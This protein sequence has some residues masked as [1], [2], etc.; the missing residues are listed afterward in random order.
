MSCENCGKHVASGNNHACVIEGKVYPISDYPTQGASCSTYEFKETVTGKIKKKSKDPLLSFIDKRKNK[1]AEES[2]TDYKKN[3]LK[4]HD[5]KAE[6][7]LKS[8]LG[9]I[10]SAGLTGT[11]VAL[12]IVGAV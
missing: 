3:L 9:W 5:A 6:V 1:V 4:K 12:L 10:V 7:T 8:G 11:L 2:A